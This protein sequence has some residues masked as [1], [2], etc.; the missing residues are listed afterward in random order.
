MGPS[1][2]T[3][4]GLT[5]IVCLQIKSQVLSA[6]AA[7]QQGPPDPDRHMRLVEW[8][9]EYYAREPARPPGTGPQPAKLHSGAVIVSGR[10]PLYFQ[11]Q[12]QRCP[13]SYPS[14]GLRSES[15]RCLHHSSRPCPGTMYT[16]ICLGNY[17][18]KQ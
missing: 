17:A 8:V 7:P 11:H 9:W 16:D 1:S 3:V 6:R 5:A 14:S 10:P 2:S 12:V 15:A 18:K 13:P 4:M